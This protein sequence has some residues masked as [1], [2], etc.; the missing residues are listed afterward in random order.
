MPARAAIAVPAE[1]GEDEVMVVIV[2][3]EPAGFDPAA[4]LEWLEARMPRYMLPRYVEV[5]ED[6]PR[7]ATTQRVKKYELRARGVGAATWERTSS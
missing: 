4:L 6:F 3:R 5:V 1:L 7:N 2:V